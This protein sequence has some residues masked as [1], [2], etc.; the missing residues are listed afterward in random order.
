M[1]SR[2]DL[3]K[4]SLGAALAGPAL[5]TAGF[6][7]DMWPAREIHSICMFPPG[8]G[9]DILVRFYAKKLQDALG[10]T[11][12]VENKVGSFGNI[13]NE[14]VARSK[15]DGYTVYIAPA[16][17]LA[18]A[19][20][21][22]TK[23][24]YNPLDD[25]EHI[26]TLFKLPFILTVA[27]DSPYKTVN[28]LVT[29]LKR[30][31]DKASYGSVST[32]SLV[33]A[34]L[35]KANF[36]LSTVEVKYKESQAGTADMLGG[37]LSFIYIDPAGSMANIKSGK[38]RALAV[39]TKDRVQALPDIPGSAEAG[40]MNS[41][42]FSWWTVHTPKGT[43]KPILDKLEAVFNKIAV[44]PD[45]KEFLANTGSDA[46]PGNGK[47]A[48]ELIVKGLKDWGDYVKLAKIEPLS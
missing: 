26:T 14:Y 20:H 25:F 16:N 22:Y 40:I 15:P 7:Q 2:R 19:P 43:P 31:G 35:F 9:A 10:K 18:I 36:G 13:A 17:L 23:L 39:T 21:L 45:T 30:R 8:S 5:T 44:E 46:L 41:D 4:S 48:R 32:V 37:N 1:L 24:N 34:E 11:V 6:A 47:L 42:L 12:I 29:D 27:A 3:M 33:G 28:D 38:I